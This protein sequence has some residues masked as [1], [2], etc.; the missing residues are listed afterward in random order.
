MVW[1]GRHDYEIAGERLL[2]RNVAID[3][4]QWGSAPPDS[5][6]SAAGCAR[7]EPIEAKQRPTQDDVE[8]FHDSRHPRVGGQPPWVQR[9]IR[10]F[11][12]RRD[13]VPGR[14]GDHERVRAPG[15]D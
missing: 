13:G 12:P 2:P 15:V 4:A 11:C 6:P 8:L 10:L 14:H 3:T 5:V 9:P 1:M 7:L